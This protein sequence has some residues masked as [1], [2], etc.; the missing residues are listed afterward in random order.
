MTTSS[1]LPH[2]L[3]SNYPQVNWEKWDSS[4]IPLISQVSLTPHANFQHGRD[5][6]VRLKFWFLPHTYVGNSLSLASALC[7]HRQ[8]FLHTW[9]AFISSLRAMC[10]FQKF[11]VYERPGHKH[12]HQKKK[13]NCFVI[14][15]QELIYWNSDLNSLFGTCR[16][17]AHF[18]FSMYLNDYIHD[19][20]DIS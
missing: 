9:T 19:G 5:I 2:S 8:T 15:L 13:I 3:Q 11:W 10:K 14:Y 4:Y 17:Y 1:P 6:W 7:T 18:H 16:F 20:P 12:L